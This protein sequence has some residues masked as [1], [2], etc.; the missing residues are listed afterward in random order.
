MKLLEQYT[1]DMPRIKAER[2]R[3]ILSKQ[4]IYE[5]TDTE[6]G[7]VVDKILNRG[8]HVEYI[9]SIGGMIYKADDKDYRWKT[10]PTDITFGDATKT[11]FDYFCFLADIEN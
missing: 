9:F 5:I 3:K 11:E 8:Q 7:E 4:Y 2:I 10:S 6:T 1:Y